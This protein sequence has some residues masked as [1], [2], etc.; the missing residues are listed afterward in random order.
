MLRIGVTGGIGSGK[1]TICNI[2]KNLGV[3]IFTSDEVGKEILSND[4]SVKQEVMKKFGKDMY[5]AQG[6]LDRERLASLVF[7]D[8]EALNDLN[9]IVHPKVSEAFDLWCQ[10]HEKSPYVIKEAAILL[11]SGA[12]HDL[13]KIIHV[14]A[15]KD[16]RIKRVMKR[17]GVSEEQVKKRMRFQYSDEERNN[18][19]DFIIMNEPNK[20][21]LPQVM[22]L[23]ELLLNEKKKW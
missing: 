17:D 8:Q 14:F 4:E 12:Y 22:E 3:P 19:A 9:T 6:D 20:D 21:M 18:L 10:E 7:N 13:D 5:N 23:H 11:E 16:E 2:F 15:P 1:S